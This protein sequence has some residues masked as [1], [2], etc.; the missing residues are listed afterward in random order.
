M[1]LPNTPSPTLPAPLSTS[2]LTEFIAVEQ[3]HPDTVAFRQFHGQEWERWTYAEVGHQAR[4]L[5]QAFRQMGLEPKAKIGVYGESSAY[6]AIT[7]LALQMGGFVAVPL[8]HQ[9]SGKVLLNRIQVAD[10]KAMVIGK[11]P[12]LQI[13]EEIMPKG[14][15]GIASPL[16]PESHTYMKWSDIQAQFPPSQGLHPSS[17]MD[18]TSISFGD[19]DQMIP[20]T[21]QE[22][23]ALGETL[24]DTL[25]MSQPRG[26]LFVHPAYP[27]NSF[28]HWIWTLG[29]AKRIPVCFASPRSWREALRQYPAYNLIAHSDDWRQLFQKL[30]DI[31]AYWKW[32]VLLSIPIFDLVLKHRTRKILGL[33]K[34]QVAVSEGQPLSPQALALFRKLGIH[35]LEM[36]GHPEAL[37]A[38]TINRP[39]LIQAGTKGQPF[40]KCEL[41]VHRESG[42]II[43]KAPWLA[44]R[45]LDPEAPSR[46]QEGW[47]HTGKRGSWAETGQLIVEGDLDKPYPAKG[48]GEMCIQQIEGKF[49]D[50][51]GIKRA[52]ILEKPN[53]KKWAY[54]NM[55]RPLSD[56]LPDK[57]RNQSAR[58]LKKVNQTLLPELRIDHLVVM[59][60]DWTAHQGGLLPSLEADRD[61]I[62][63]KASKLKWSHPKLPAVLLESED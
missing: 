36:Y 20:H 43:A 37:G 52:V 32:M 26:S 22:I 53:G 46:I 7:H 38:L 55:E 13:L 21:F 24:E 61:W 16:C 28:H 34:L 8:S 11:M 48:T 45:K 3:S 4:V 23:Q 40:P 33:H 5:V 29:I 49:T 17:P 62:A 14:L 15:I 39:A 1:S 41:K 58:I 44:K 60:A 27:T 51:H 56:L 47:L 9:L 12:T 35:V 19:Q 63:D 42:E 18:I 10:V 57:L 31:H 54:L 25:D 2:L 50:I 30:S 59:E 6:H